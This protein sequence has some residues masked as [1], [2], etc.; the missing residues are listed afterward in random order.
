MKIRCLLTIVASRD[1]FAVYWGNEF[2]GKFNTAYW[3]LDQV[4][5]HLEKRGYRVVDI[6]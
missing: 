3:T 2:Y 4:V 1:F 5:I 6:S